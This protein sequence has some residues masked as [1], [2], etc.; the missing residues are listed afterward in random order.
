MFLIS[1]LHTTSFV[2]FDSK[3]L[4]DYSESCLKSTLKALSVAE[5]PHLDQGRAHPRHL[6]CRARVQVEHFQSDLEWHHIQVGCYGQ[7]S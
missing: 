6:R 4:S 1:T 5:A 3:V 7:D 2:I